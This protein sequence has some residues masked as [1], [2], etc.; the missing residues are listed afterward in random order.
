VGQLLK[1]EPFFTSLYDRLS[2]CYIGFEKRFY[3]LSL[4]SHSTFEKDYYRYTLL[5]IN[6]LHD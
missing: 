3:L 6:S 5:L 1:L 4:P 2:V